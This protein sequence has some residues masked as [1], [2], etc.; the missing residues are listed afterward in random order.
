MY[1][2]AL[3]A[4]ERIK[5]REE[6]VKRLC[7]GFNIKMVE[8]EVLLFLYLIQA[9][10]I[11]FSGLVFFEVKRVS[12]VKIIALSVIFAACILAVR[13]IYLTFEIPFGSHTIVLILMLTLIVKMGAKASWGISFSLSFMAMS[14]ILI[15]SVLSI[16]VVSLLGLTTNE[17]LSNSQ[18]HI[19]AGNIENLP[20]FLFFIAVKFFDLRYS[21]ILNLIQ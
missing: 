21:K 19:L 14:L 12:K 20:L 10:L 9:M 7:R 17:V 4:V 11:V 18:M 3:N 2:R 13:T 16:P 15:G 1:C 5:K 8:I 6:V